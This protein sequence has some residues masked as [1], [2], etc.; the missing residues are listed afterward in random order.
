MDVPSYRG[1]ARFRGS[2]DRGVSAHRRSAS[3]D[4]DGLKID[5]VAE[6][7]LHTDSIALPLITFYRPTRP[8]AG[9]IRLPLC[10]EA[11]ERTA[12]LLTATFD[13]EAFGDEA[14]R[15]RFRAR[16]GG[17]AAFCGPFCVGQN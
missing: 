9:C 16:G 7:G 4:P 5:L 1:G 2:V 14:G 12:R 6:P 15:Q 8:S 10:V 3:C 17:P 13:Y 11:P